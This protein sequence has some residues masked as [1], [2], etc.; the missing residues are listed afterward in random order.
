VDL[1]RVLLVFDWWR[2][3][4]SPGGKFE[5]GETSREAAGREL[6]EETGLV[7]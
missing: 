5:P 4:V 7:G 3:W 6:L 1:S 2:G